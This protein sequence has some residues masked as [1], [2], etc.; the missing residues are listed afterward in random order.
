MWQSKVPVEGFFCCFCLEEQSTHAADF[1]LF[2]Y[3]D[4]KVLVD[5]GDGQQDSCS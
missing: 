1:A 4:L 5:D 2:L 3:K